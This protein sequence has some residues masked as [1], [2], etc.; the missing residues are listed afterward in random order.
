[1]SV[2]VYRVQEQMAAMVTGPF[3]AKLLMINEGHKLNEAQNRVHKSPSHANSNNINRTAQEDIV[4]YQFGINE[5][6]SI[7]EKS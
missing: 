6:R 4:C 2:K 7:R 3:V 5:H 1:M